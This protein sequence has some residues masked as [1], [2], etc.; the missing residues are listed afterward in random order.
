[1][2][3]AFSIIF[4]GLLGVSIYAFD[5]ISGRPDPYRLDVSFVYDFVP[6]GNSLDESL[7][8]DEKTKKIHQERDS[9]NSPAISN[10][11]DT[12][13]DEKKYGVKN[14]IDGADSIYIK[15]HLGTIKARIMSI[16]NYPAIARRMGWTGKTH[17]TF[18]LNTEG[19]VYNV[20]VKKSSGYPVLDKCAVKAVLS[21]SGLPK[22]PTLTRVT[23]PLSFSL[24]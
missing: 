6:K 3:V 12:R 14:G 21:L 9:S 1:M 10:Q 24:N 11:K 16:I 20:T 5:K 15:Q 23:F 19:K 2:G 13:S 18:F 4:H 7:L 8:E 17:I 22:P